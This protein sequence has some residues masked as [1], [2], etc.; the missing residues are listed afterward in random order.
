LKVPDDWTKAGTWASADGRNCTVK[1]TG[2]CSLKF[3]GNSNLKSLS[4]TVLTSGVAGDDYQ[5]Q[6]YSKA[7]SVPTTGTTYRM[8]VSFMNGTTL[9]NKVVKN[10]AK[11]THNFALASLPVSAIGTYDR[12]IVK[13]EFKATSGTAWFDD[14][15][16][17][18]LP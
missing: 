14:A 9:I 5:L 11:G 4:Y 7:S 8:S 1:R 12:I 3:T 16:L 15:S 13:I 10:F 2:A 18:F 17:V 6:L